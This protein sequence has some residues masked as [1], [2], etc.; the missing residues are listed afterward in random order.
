MYRDLDVFAPGAAVL[1]VLA[2]YRLAMGLRAE[3]PWARRAGVAAAA[4]SACVVLTTL[5]V[6]SRPAAGLRRAMAFAEETPARPGGQR[7]QLWDFVGNRADQLGDRA[8]SIAAHE[9]SARLAPTGRA[10]I[11]LAL[12]HARAGEYGPALSTLRSSAPSDPARALVLAGMVGC[13]LA[14]GDSAAAESTA[15]ELRFHTPS[16]ADRRMVVRFAH[17]FP[18]LFPDTAGFARRLVRAPAPD[19]GRRAPT[20]HSPRRPAVPHA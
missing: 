2:A 16:P 5:A 10:L 14:L 15:V 19:P 3:M 6:Q 18:E 1:T 9:R 20:R 4:A 12:A 8:L 13:Q 7:A 11:A 17:E